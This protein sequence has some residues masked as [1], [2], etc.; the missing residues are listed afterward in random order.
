MIEERDVAVT[1]IGM[2]SAYESLERTEKDARTRKKEIKEMAREITE[3]F[4]VKIGDD[5]EVFPELE[6]VFIRHTYFPQGI[7]VL[8]EHKNVPELIKVL[9]RWGYED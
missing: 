8:I 7:G 1:L 4:A 5:L 6:G 3:K 2:K 9:K